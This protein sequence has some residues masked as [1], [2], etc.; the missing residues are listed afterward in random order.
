MS[1]GKYNL[2]NLSTEML[3]RAVVKTFMQ[4]SIL[5]EKVPVITISGNAYSFNQV[6]EGFVV[7]KREMGQDVVNVQEIQTTKVTEPLNI[8]TT[9]AKVDRAMQLVTETDLMALEMELQSKAMAHEMQGEILNKVK[10]DAGVVVTVPTAQSVIYVEDIL[11]AMDNMQCNKDNTFIFA[12]PKTARKITSEAMSSGFLYGNKDEFGKVIN[13][14]DGVALQPVKALEDNEV[15]VIYFSTVDGV[16]LAVNTGVK[17]YNTVQGVFNV[18]DAELLAVP[19][20]K[21][22]KAVAHIT[23]S[24]AKRK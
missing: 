20:V 6:A 7:E 22:T 11:G 8:Y 3:D 5:F 4:E 13:H 17:T 10:A 2:L 14:I 23:V 21:N 24:V 9:R 1:L 15:L 12:N 19:V 16:S 18:T